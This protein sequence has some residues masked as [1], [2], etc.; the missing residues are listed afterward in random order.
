M[1]LISPSGGCQ[2]S[3]WWDT[4]AAATRLGR[5]SPMSRHWCKSAAC[6]LASEH[7]PAETLDYCNKSQILP[8]SWRTVVFLHLKSLILLNHAPLRAETG[9]CCIWSGRLSLC[10]V[11]QKM[12]QVSRLSH[13]LSPETGIPKGILAF[14]EKNL[15]KQESNYLLECIQSQLPK[16]CQARE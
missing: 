5:G 8:S 6:S 9:F 1:S 3:S 13:W 16:S 2:K 14:W 7:M 12:C 4:Y 10:S 15:H 11:W